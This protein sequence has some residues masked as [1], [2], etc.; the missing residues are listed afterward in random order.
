[1]AGKFGQKETPGTVCRKRS[2]KGSRGQPA[3]SA[4]RVPAPQPSARKNCR[5]SACEATTVVAVSRPAF[6]G[7]FF[8]SVTPVGWQKTSPTVPQGAVGLLFS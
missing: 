5:F 4:A 3:E 7:R 8:Q 2:R 6:T 1:M